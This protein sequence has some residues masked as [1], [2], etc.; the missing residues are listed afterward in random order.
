MNSNMRWGP[1][2][3]VLSITMSILLCKRQINM[4]VCTS[5]IKQHKSPSLAQPDSSQKR[6]GLVTPTNKFGEAGM[7]STLNK[8]LFGGRRG[9]I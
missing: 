1:I 5:N 2:R 8:G 4:T 3:Y 7:G 9:G 6:E